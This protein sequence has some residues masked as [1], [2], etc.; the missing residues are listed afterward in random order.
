MTGNTTPKGKEVEFWLVSVRNFLIRRT[1]RSTERGLK[2]TGNESRE[3]GNLI[4]LSGNDQPD[5]KRMRYESR[6]QQKAKA[7][8]EETGLLA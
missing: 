7:Q 5:V 2:V 1:S 3:Q 8:P 4:F 6:M